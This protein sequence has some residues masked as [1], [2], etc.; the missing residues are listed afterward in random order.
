[1]GRLND[2]AIDYIVLPDPLF[3]P[4]ELSGAISSEKPFRAVVRRYFLDETPIVQM[5]I[6][7]LHKMGF[8][9]VWLIGSIVCFNRS[10]VRLNIS[11]QLTLGI[12][13]FTYRI[14]GRIHRCRGF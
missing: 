3:A 4:L 6:G 5:I 11:R 1:M 8:G 2:L 7:V 14:L 12:I 10:K 9:G 13:H